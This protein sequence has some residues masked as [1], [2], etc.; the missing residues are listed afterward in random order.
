MER[1]K[2]HKRKKEFK[3]GVEK[4]LDAATAY[5]TYEDSVKLLDDPVAF[6]SRVIPHEFG[7][8]INVPEVKLLEED[9][10][11]PMKCAD[12]SV[13]FINMIKM[14]SKNGCW[15]INLDCDG[16]YVEGLEYNEW[17]HPPQ[18]P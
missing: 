4:F 1:A 13:R 11:Q 3:M 16:G 6:P 10:I 14:A 5:I 8:W 12:Y 17:E 2:K 15:W 9:L 7:W 18:L